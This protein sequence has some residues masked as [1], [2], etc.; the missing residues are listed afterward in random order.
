MTLKKSPILEGFFSLLIDD[1]AVRESE[2]IL[3]IHHTDAI[4]IPPFHSSKTF[5]K[6]PTFHLLFERSCFSTLN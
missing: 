6:S 4:P 1:F 3:P 5:L 2:Q